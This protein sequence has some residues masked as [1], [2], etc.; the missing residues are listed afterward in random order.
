[1]VLVFFVD[2]FGVLVVIVV[3]AVPSKTQAH[4]MRLVF[5][6]KFMQRRTGSK[7]L[8]FGQSKSK[9]CCPFLQQLTKGVTGPLLA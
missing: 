8:V 7:S 9:V 5:L 6:S 1:M 3:A 2:F 4:F